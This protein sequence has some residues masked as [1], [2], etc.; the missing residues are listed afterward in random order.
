MTN[1]TI[2]KVCSK[3]Q[4]LLESESL[5]RFLIAV[6]SGFGDPAYWEITNFMLAQERRLRH[7]DT[8]S[9]CQTEIGATA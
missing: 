2:T 3:R 5:S 4:T 6:A 9:A 7:E 8:C 1:Q